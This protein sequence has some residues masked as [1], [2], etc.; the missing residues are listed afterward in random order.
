MECGEFLLPL[1]VCVCVFGW[2]VLNKWLMDLMLLDSTS[3]VGSL[4]QRFTGLCVLC[5]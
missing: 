5:S 1:C 3:T 4:P 2:L